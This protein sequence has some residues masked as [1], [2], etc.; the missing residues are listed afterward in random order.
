MEIITALKKLGLTQNEIDIYLF[1]LK[2]EGI[3][4]PQIYK[5][6]GLDK[7]SAY[8]ALSLLQEKELILVSGETRN[9]EYEAKP[10]DE[11]ERF[12]KQKRQEIKT[13]G[14]TINDFVADIE[15]YAKSNYKSQSI[16]IFEGEKSYFAFNE[17]RLADGVKLIRE[18]GVKEFLD[19]VVVGVDYENYM[20]EYISRRVK[21]G[22]KIRCLYDD[23]EDYLPFDYTNPK[24]LKQARKYTGE[25]DLNSFMSTYGNKVGFFTIKVNTFMGVVI[26][27]VFI[28]KLINSMYDAIWKV[29]EEVI[30]AK[31]N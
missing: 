26:E 24:I 16:K 7:S 28:T 4:A 9:Q 17:A 20:N 15:S 5:S 23:R 30:D 6:L 12:Y 2:N 22:I 25:L 14:N 11:L 18:I 31:Q 1:L 21:K 8:R 27:D 29:S 19:K 3:A 10:A 13:I